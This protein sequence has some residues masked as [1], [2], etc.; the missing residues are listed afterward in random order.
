MAYQLV[1]H[2]RIVRDLERTPA[3]IAKALRS[4]LEVLAQEP[5]GRHDIKRIQGISTQPPT[6]RLRVGTY[7]ILLK[8]DHDTQQ[9]IVLKL[10]PRRSVYGGLG[11][12]D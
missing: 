9:I 1:A 3:A 5:A 8:I 6:L 11:H 10:G 12:L 2:P 4:A 7:R